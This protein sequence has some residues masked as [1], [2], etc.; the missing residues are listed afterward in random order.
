M[1]DRQTKT[2]SC[3]AC[4]AEN[5]KQRTQFHE[6]GLP[7]NENGSILLAE[8]RADYLALVLTG[9]VHPFLPLVEP[10]DVLDSSSRLQSFGR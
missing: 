9:D 7:Q 2:S 1:L 10:S 6:P 8:D 4:E 5:R 3:E